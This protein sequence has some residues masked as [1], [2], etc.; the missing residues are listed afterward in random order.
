MKSDIPKVMHLLSGNPM[1][2]Y[3]I[4]LALKIDGSNV[5]LVVGY[6]KEMIIDYVTK[7]YKNLNIAVQNNN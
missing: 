4:D 3:V 1:I 2:S 7:K 6:R 5:I